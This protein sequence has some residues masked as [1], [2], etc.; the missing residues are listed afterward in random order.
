MHA[1]AVSCA[2]NEF[3]RFD[4]PSG[5]TCGAY[6][7]D[8]LASGPGGQLINPGATSG[9]EYCSLSNSDQFLASVAIEWGTRWRNYGLGFSYIGF[10]IGMAMIGYYV[11]RVRKWGPGSL[12]MGPSAVMGRV[13]GLLSVHGKSVATE[14]KKGPA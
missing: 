5:Q 14:G 8:Y 7:A 2:A 12:M 1:R 13:R 6:L 4:P 9:C 11:F 3:A 10:N